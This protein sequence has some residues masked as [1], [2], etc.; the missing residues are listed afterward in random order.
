MKDVNSGRVLNYALQFVEFF[1]GL[2][3]ESQKIIDALDDLGSRW[4][5]A[6]YERSTRRVELLGIDQTTTTE[7]L[8][9]VSHLT[10]ASFIEVGLSVFC[11]LIMCVLCFY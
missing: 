4:F 10:P 7:L 11:V 3:G 2:V 9:R 1:G 8:T 6:F 5:Q